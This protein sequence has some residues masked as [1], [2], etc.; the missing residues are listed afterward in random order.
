MHKYRSLLYIVKYF[1]QA[2][3]S[4]IGTELALPSR[5]DTYVPSINGKKQKKE[6]KWTKK[7]KC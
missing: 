4:N 1:L 5:R 7:G 2:L 3:P 6:K